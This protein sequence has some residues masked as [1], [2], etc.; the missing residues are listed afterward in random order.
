MKWGAWMV[1]VAITLGY[2]ANGGDARWI[3]VFA[4]FDVVAF[5]GLLRSTR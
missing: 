2:A 5:V 3:A 1:G 4:L